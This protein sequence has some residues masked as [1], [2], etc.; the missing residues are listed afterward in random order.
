MEEFSFEG[1][2]MPWLPGQRS[3]VASAELLLRLEGLGDSL[4]IGVLGLIRQYCNTTGVTSTLLC[5]SRCLLLRLSRHQV[6]AKQSRKL[7]AEA[8][9]SSFVCARPQKMLKTHLL[10]RRSTEP[11]RKVSEKF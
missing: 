9:H 8:K 3:L 5:H 2:G 1:H 7:R 10:L 6:L 4:R 11:D